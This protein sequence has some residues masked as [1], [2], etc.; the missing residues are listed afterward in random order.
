MCV[1]A[2]T[3]S[4]HNMLSLHAQTVCAITVGEYE[5]KKCHMDK[6]DKVALAQTFTYTG[7]SDL[8]KYVN[9]ASLNTLASA[10]FVPE[11]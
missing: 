1:H 4:L 3:L 2:Y 7:G 6:V 10:Y 8:D 11:A 9:L 5:K